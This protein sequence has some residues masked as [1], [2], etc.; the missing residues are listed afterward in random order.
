[1]IDAGDKLSGS[2]PPARC[3]QIRVH[4]ILGGASAASSLAANASTRQLTSGLIDGTNI[5]TRNS[6]SVMSCHLPN[7]ADGK[8]ALAPAHPAAGPGVTLSSN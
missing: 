6:C 7:Q 1:M 8:A 4:S 2:Q 3:S 5:S